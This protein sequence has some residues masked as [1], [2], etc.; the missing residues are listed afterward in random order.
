MIWSMKHKVFQIANIFCYIYPA[1]NYS[2][3]Y[4]TAWIFC[5]I[6]PA[7]NSPPTMLQPELSVYLPR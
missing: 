6:Y 5:Y 2:S 4:A 1:N 7:N 3:Y